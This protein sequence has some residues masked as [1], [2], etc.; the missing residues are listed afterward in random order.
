VPD[1]EKGNLHFLRPASLELQVAALRVG[2]Y[3]VMDNTLFN[4]V[5]AYIPKRKDRSYSGKDSGDCLITTDPNMSQHCAKIFDIEFS[6]QEY[7]R[8]HISIMCMTSGNDQLK[9][10]STTSG[11]IPEGRRNLLTMRSCKFWFFGI[12]YRVKIDE[13]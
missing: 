11:K 7:H 2:I 10:S 6:M 12:C 5:A 3:C 8:K 4:Q 1:D 9:S 13:G